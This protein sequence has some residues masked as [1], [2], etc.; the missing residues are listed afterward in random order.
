MTLHVNTALFE[1]VL[2]PILVAVLSIVGRVAWRLAVRESVRT[3]N[4]VENV[5]HLHVEQP[6]AAHDPEALAALGLALGKSNERI[7]HLEKLLNEALGRIGSLERN[8]GHLI[9][10]IHTLHKGIE[11]GSIPPMLEIPTHIRAL[12]GI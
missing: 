6:P 3:T 7:D 12:L 2:C 5:E 11:D 1:Y 10:W 4:R 8:E 9:A